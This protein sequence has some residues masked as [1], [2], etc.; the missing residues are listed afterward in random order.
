MK[1]TTENKP[2]VSVLCM[3]HDHASTVAQTIESIVTQK[4]DFPF[5]LIIHDDASNDGTAD[6]VR[7]YAERYPDVIVPIFQSENKYRECN[8]FYT[9]MRPLIRGC[10]V[11]IC[12]GD[13]CWTDPEKLAVQVAAMRSDPDITMCFHAVTQNSPDG[14]ITVRPLKRDGFVPA[15]TV[16]RRGG[17]F[18]PTVS[19]MFRRDVFDD[20]PDYRLK[21]DVYDYPAQILAS[22][23]GKVMY[24]DRDM[25]LYRFG[26]AGSWTGSRSSDTD[27]I[28]LNCETEW[29]G[30]FNSATD[31]RYSSAVDFHLSHMWFT[32]YR[33]G[34]NLYT[35]EQTE[36]YVSRLP[37]R[38]KLGFRVW[39]TLY[40]LVG[41]R[42]DKLWYA[43]KKTLLK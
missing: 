16:I 28:H 12:D 7:R 42:A 38:D 25:A 17:Q 6:V 5:E 35:R 11:A 41:K 43:V 1:S 34:L 4:T 10:Y 30:E 24:L 33:K 37:F 32:E 36:K 15:E 22:V 14:D 9:Y 40:A 20:W 26:H 31:N 21:A 19:L 23:K 2:L 13:D 39:L 27:F 8:I 29:L 3:T 18:C